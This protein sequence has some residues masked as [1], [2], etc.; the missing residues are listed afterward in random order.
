MEGIRHLTVLVNPTASNG[1]S[2]REWQ[3]LLPHFEQ[4]FADTTI[5]VIETSS[6]E[7]TVQLAASHP[8]DLLVSASG[9]GTIS[10][11]TQGLMQRPAAERPALSVIPLGSG[12][13]FAKA[14]GVPMNPYLAIS[15]LPR[16]QRSMIDVGRVNNIYFVNT[17]SFGVDA[18]V[19]DRTNELRKA[20][21]RRGIL[22]FAQAA[23][24][25]IVRDLRSHHCSMIIDGNH[26]E[27]NLLICAI[28]N[29]PYYGGG[30]KVAPNAMLDDG[31]FNLCLAENTSKLNAL[32]AMA[33]LAGGRHENLKIIETLKGSLVS[34]DFDA[35]VAAQIDGEKLSSSANEDGYWH[36]DVELIPRA[37]EVISMR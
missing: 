7:H 14:L 34:L 32:Y 11:L 23:I 28:Q 6:R 17:L 37:L 20:T 30:F 31:Q 13:D 10:N 26:H 12:N 24:S 4:T 27:R 19:A 9:D 18:V 15:R 33:R 1:N 22:L 5:E 29:G 36:F 21:H 2:K 16:G 35:P 8:T 25:S 3:K